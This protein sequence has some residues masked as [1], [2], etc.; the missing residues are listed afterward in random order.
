[1][2]DDDDTQ[3]DAVSQLQATKELLTEG[4]RIAY[5]GLTRLELS[6]ML[7][8][9][10][11]LVQTSSKSKKKTAVAAESMKMW[12]QKMMI[13]LY[14]HMDISSAEQVMIEQLSSH[15]VMPQD[16]TPVLMANARV[17]NPMAEKDARSS[18]SIPTSVDREPWSRTG[19]R[20]A[21]ALR[22]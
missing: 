3:R 10:E 19:C 15:G 11:E 14:S 5:V 22:S 2:D 13:R 4:Q 8:D 16:L 6:S 17:R 18:V 21:A 12:S 7:K 20:A 1:M 9:A